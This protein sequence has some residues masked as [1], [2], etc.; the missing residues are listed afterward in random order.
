[1]TLDS[2]FIPK[3][4]SEEE[5]AKM[6]PLPKSFSSTSEQI[7]IGSS[8]ELKA[9]QMAEEQEKQIGIEAIRKKI[10]DVDFGSGEKT[11][12]SE[13]IPSMPPPPPIENSTLK[14]RKN[15]IEQREIAN[16]RKV[17]DV[18]VRNNAFIIHMLNDMEEMGG[19]HNENSAVS[20]KATYEDDV[21][22]LL[23]LEPSISAS[24]VISGDK[25][26]VWPGAGGFLLGG[27][28][29]GEAEVCDHGSHGE[30]IKRRGGKE[31]SIEKIDEVVGR[32]DKGSQ[33][34][35]EENGEHGMNEIVVNN[36]EVFGFFQ[37]AEKDADGKFWAFGLGMK[38]DYQKANSDRERGM[39]GRSSI[40]I[41]VFENNL[42]AYNKRFM[43]ARERGIPLYVMTGNREFYRCLGVD[44]DGSI[45]IAGEK[46][47]PEEVAKG[48]S[49]LISSKRKE[50]GQRILEK[51]IFRKSELQEEA[52]KIVE[53]L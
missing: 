27:G 6:P 4:P 12:S 7:P 51:N 50:I 29:I 42:T 18:M 36:P 2:K 3:I 13:K 26:K 44:D 49:G 8:A 38:E 30:G 31:S 47:T 23:S 11:N 1:M 35:R 17:E 22:I 52:R 14:E 45:I 10:A 33:K 21:D 43:T 24:S 20:K 32:H 9:M 46:L 19:H 25:T 5:I 41:E 34:I 37:R 48:R 15:K 53:S 40:N 28:E 39:S 16:S